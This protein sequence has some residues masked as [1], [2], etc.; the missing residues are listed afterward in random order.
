VRMLGPRVDLVEPVFIAD[1]GAFTALHQ[2]NGTP[3]AD[4]DAADGGR[5]PRE[6]VLHG[7][8]HRVDQR[9]LGAGDKNSRPPGVTIEERGGTRGINGC[10]ARRERL[11][12]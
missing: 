1:K 2:D 5:D 10:S 12:R 11:R 9:K 6:S 8:Q 4:L 3:A 7:G